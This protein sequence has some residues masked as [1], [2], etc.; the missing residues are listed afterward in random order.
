MG[1]QIVV[2]PRQYSSTVPGDDKAAPMDSLGDE[3][4][5]E[6][7]RV[8]ES[9]VIPISNLDFRLRVLDCAVRL[10]GDFHAWVLLQRNNPNLI[11]HNVGFLSDCIKYITSG[12]RDLAPM[13]WLGL[14]GEK[15]S[16]TTMAHHMTQPDLAVSKDVDT[17]EII[18]LWCSRPQGFEDLLVSL[19]LFFGHSLAGEEA[20]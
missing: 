5:T 4:V 17:A 19:F 12:K 14:V 6:L 8:Y 15:S 18:Q 16:H 3:T 13:S 20:E 2:F 9:G 7:F 10:F 1:K 11:G